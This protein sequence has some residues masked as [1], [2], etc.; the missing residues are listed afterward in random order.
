MFVVNTPEVVIVF[1]V[2]VVIVFVLNTLEAVI[3]VVDVVKVV[4]FIKNS[5]VTSLEIS[6]KF[7][8]PG[9]KMDVNITT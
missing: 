4:M 8:N 7:N 9:P 5:S 6:H 1:T 3:F 2:T